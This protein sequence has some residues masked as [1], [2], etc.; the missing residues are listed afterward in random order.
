MIQYGWVGRQNGRKLWS[1]EVVFTKLKIRKYRFIIFFG[2]V[3]FGIRYFSVFG[4][5]TSVS[6]SLFWNTSVFSIS[7]GYRPRTSLHLWS[8]FE[9]SDLCTATA[10]RVSEM[11]NIIRN[12]LHFWDIAFFS[13]GGCQ[14]PWTIFPD[15]S[16]TLSCI[17]LPVLLVVNRILITC[18]PITTQKWISTSCVTSST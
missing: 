16:I 3:F 15:A 1:Q 2:I 10:E 7:I 4:I 11:C 9:L 5:P 6:V 12:V 13:E 8:R 14:W 17:Q 18:C